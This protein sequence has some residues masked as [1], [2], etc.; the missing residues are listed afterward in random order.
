MEIVPVIDL[1]DG[2]VVRA[3]HGDR[4]SYRPIETPL[5]ATSEATAVVAGL[6]SLHPFRS[7]YVADIDAIEGRG[8]SGTILGRI[9]ER[10]PDL[11][12]WVDNGCADR[13]AAEA[14]L[15]AFPRASLVLGSESQRDDSLLRSLR[16]DP[17]IVLSLDFRG[18]AFI[19]PQSLIADARTW[20]SRIILMT[21]AR[22]G[23]D[24]GPDFARFAE[25]LMR[26]GD[27]RA[28]LA[29]GL[30]GREDLPAVAA[31]GAAGILVASALHDGRLASADLAGIAR[32]D[33]SAS[34]A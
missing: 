7:L 12:L 9:R 26:A 21:L 5:S 16:H 19:G 8:D 22:V 10:F 25:I 27:R 2:V 3:R 11:S 32:R 1:K 18:D 28:Y 6:L 14:F 29:G 23:S 34:P 20:P 30:R 33:G 4:A 13:R 31:S 15:A 17:R 24:A